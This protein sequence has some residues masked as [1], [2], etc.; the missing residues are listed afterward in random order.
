MYP[1][2]KNSNDKPRHIYCCGC[3]KDV[4]ARLTSGAEIYPHRL[5]LRRLP[6]WKCDGC[7]NHVGCHHK[8]KAPTR[9]LGNIPTHEIRQA[10]KHIHDLLDPLWQ[11]GKIKRGKLYAKLAEATGNKSYHTGEIRTV[12]DAR[13]VYR[14]AKELSRELRG[15]A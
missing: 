14:I 12:E 3:Q 1:A 13:T 15:A 8:T 9:P 11:G 6:F 2:H 5:D 7:G 4:E 10:R